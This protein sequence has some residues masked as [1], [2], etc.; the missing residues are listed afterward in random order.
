MKREVNKSGLSAGMLAAGTNMGNVA[1]WKFTPSLSGKKKEGEDLWSL[2]APATVEGP[3]RKV[4]VSKQASTRAR[5]EDGC[6]LEFGTV[7]P[8]FQDHPKKEKKRKCKIGLKVGRS[9]VRSS[10][11]VRDCP[12][13][14]ATLVSW[15]STHPDVTI[16][17]DRR[18]KTVLFPFC[19]SSGKQDNV[20]LC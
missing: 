5:V 19:L 12:L 15:L 9:M 13:F 6:A 4:E 10:F 7:E 3:V 20:R 1:L 2:Q 18:S 17:V 16:M 8:Q 14:N 11:M